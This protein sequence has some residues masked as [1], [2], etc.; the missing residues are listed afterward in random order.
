MLTPSKVFYQGDILEKQKYILNTIYC[1]QIFVQN[2]AI[3]CIIFFYTP[4]FSSALKTFQYIIEETDL[5]CMGFHVRTWRV[6]MRKGHWPNCHE[7]FN[8]VREYSQ[9]I[10]SD[11]SSK[12][13]KCTFTALGSKK[14]YSL[15]AIQF[16]TCTDWSFYQLNDKRWIL[17]I[18]YICYFSQYFTPVHWS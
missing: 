1:I 18:T 11:W 3:N 15:N 6:W 12:F 7:I 10:T 17:Y 5:D 8:D 9:L 13:C 4:Q 2:T 14:L 16:I